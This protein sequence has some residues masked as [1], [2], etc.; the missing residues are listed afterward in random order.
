MLGEKQRNSLFCF[1]KALESVLS[2][3]QKADKILELKANLNVA[4]ALLER[5]FPIAIQVTMVK[6]AW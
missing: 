3:S 5:N 1:L 6:D 2:E 4:L